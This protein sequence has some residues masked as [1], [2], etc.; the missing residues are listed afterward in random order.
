MLDAVYL[1]ELTPST[2]S[3]I[4]SVPEAASY[5]NLFYKVEVAE[6][7]EAYLYWNDCEL[8]IALAEALS[9]GWT[10]VKNAHGE[11]IGFITKEAL[12]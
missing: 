12:T 10:L 1:T 3:N 6:F 9:L 8:T 7:I 2:Q 11:V 4:M 5:L